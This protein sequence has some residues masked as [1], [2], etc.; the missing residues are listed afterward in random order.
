MIF[1]LNLNI[2]FK[3]GFISKSDF[4]EKIKFK[5]SFENLANNIESIYDQITDSS[6][7][8]FQFRLF[9][10]KLR[11]TI[12]FAEIFKQIASGQQID[13]FDW[14]NNYKFLN[15]CGNKFNINIFKNA[16]KDDYHRIVKGPILGKV[17]FLTILEFK[18]YS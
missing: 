8:K 10:V 3:R 12:I 1:T 6:I 4:L 18:K 14:E 2:Y 11:L 13:K 5:Q 17:Q 15:E 9:F 7:E 16:K